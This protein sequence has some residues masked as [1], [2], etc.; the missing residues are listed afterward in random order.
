M[1]Y[2]M[3]AK[4]DNFV[5]P[6][7]FCNL[8]IL[9]FASS[10]QCSLMTTLIII[11]CVYIAVNL[12]ML[13]FKL[14]RKSWKRWLSW[15]CSLSDLWT[16]LF[17]H[18]VIGEEKWWKRPVILVLFVLVVPAFLL[19]VVVFTLAPFFVY[20]NAIDGY[21]WEIEKTQKEAA[22]EPPCTIPSPKNWGAKT[23]LTSV[24][25]SLDLPFQ[26]DIHDVFYVEN[27]YDTV[28]NNFIMEHYEELRCK[29]VNRD[30]NLVYLPKLSGLEVSH[31]VLQYMFPYLSPNTSFK[32]DI[33]AVEMLKQHITTKNRS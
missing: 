32:N 16:E 3:F 12:A 17:S 7:M 19:V 8:A 24:Q 33:T 29:F 10:I 25:I 30:M 6:I 15:C 28:V 13:L 20:R 26:P 27:E 5:V 23:D 2:F 1:L 21:K 14:V 22:K 11:I 18:E 9:I 4:V 31:E